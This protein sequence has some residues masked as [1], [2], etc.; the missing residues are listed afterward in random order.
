MAKPDARALVAAAQRIVDAGT[1][2]R[3]QGR[4]VQFGVD[5]IG[6]VAVPAREIGLDCPDRSGYSGK[7][8][9]PV[10]R[11]IMESPPF[12]KLAGPTEGAV[13]FMVYRKRGHL[14]ILTERGGEWW[15]L[16]SH[17]L[18]GC[19]AQPW[20]KWEKHCEAIYAFEELVE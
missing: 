11:E 4:N 10:L 8:G 17:F 20:S 15:M 19:C 14:G 9:L 7:H 18:Y 6:F 12:V 13:P 5:C 2:F 16:H 3:H 1:K